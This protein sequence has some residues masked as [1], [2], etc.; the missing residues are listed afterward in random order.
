MDGL[1]GIYKWMRKKNIIQKNYKC[2]YAFVGIG[3][4]SLHNLY[5]VIDYLKVPLKYIVCK[6]Q[7]SMDLINRNYPSLTGT[8]NLETALNDDEVK[9]LFICASPVD[10]YELTRKALLAH[11]NVFVEKPVCTSSGELQALIAAEKASTGFCQVG[12]QKRYSICTA[13]LKKRLKKEKIL[14]YNYRFCVGPYPEGNIYWDIFIHPV[15]YVLHLFGNAEV[16]SVAATPPYKGKST[17]FLHLKHKNDIIGNVEISTNHFWSEALEELQVNTGNGLYE[18]SNH[19]LL[20]YRPKPSTILSLPL[21]K[22]FNFVPEKH[23]L[24][25]TH[26]FLPVFQNNQ[27]LSQG[28]FGEIQ[29]FVEQCESKSANNRSSLDSLSETYR[30]LELI[31][32][33]SN[34]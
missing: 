12:M 17:V 33:K 10:H 3:N 8:N 34:I 21:E 11:K 9:G 14:S 7:R 20:Y 13:L 31:Q 4:H 30:V 16:L 24:F 32:N 6:S 26:T 2:S 28:Y 1:I 19:Q 25:N 22:I 27:L 18:M 23:Y 29:S 5:P 15:D